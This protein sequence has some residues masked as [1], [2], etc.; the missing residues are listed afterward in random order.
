MTE[1]EILLFVCIVGMVLLMAIAF[2]FGK[3]GDLWLTIADLQD[4]QRGVMH[5]LMVLKTEVD[6]MAAREAERLR[7]GRIS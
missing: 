1:W 7:K 6:A 4:D 2:L 5:D 3:I